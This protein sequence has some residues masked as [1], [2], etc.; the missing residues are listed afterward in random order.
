MDVDKQAAKL[1]KKIDKLRW[2][3]RNEVL[4]KKQ[5]DKKD[6]EIVELEKQIKAFE[7][8][9]MPLK[10]TKLVHKTYE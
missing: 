9:L 1:N 3:I 4:T 7:G 2:Q 5:K 10:V 6:E 8:Q